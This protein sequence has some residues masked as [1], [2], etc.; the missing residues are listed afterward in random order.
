HDPQR[1]RAS[2][3]ATPILAG[4]MQPT[5]AAC[6]PASATAT[7]PENPSCTCSTRCMPGWRGTSSAGPKTTA[8]T[9][10]LEEAHPML[11]TSVTEL[12]GIEHPIVLGGMGSATNADLVVAVCEAGGLGILG[13]SGSA[14]DEI[15]RQVEAIRSRTAKP[16]G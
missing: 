5:V 9:L 8:G 4:S 13:A 7:G 14:P 16:F 11:R 12:F 2:P 10:L 6:S 3:T 15:H 1:R